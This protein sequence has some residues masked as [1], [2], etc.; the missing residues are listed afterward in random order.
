MCMCLI[1]FLCPNVST[2]G[3]SV[4]RIVSFNGLRRY[5]EHLRKHNAAVRI[6]SAWGPEVSAVE[7]VGTVGITIVNQQFLMVYATHKSGD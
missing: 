6:Q 5:A 4:P 7:F 2:K 1:Q 3:Y